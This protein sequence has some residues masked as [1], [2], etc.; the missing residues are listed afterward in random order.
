M[1]LTG[2]KTRVI[3]VMLL[4]ISITGGL[5]LARGHPS[6]DDPHAGT[7]PA[8]PRPSVSSP[9]K[10]IVSLAPSITEV[11]VM[12][13][14]ASWLVGVT[15]FSDHLEAVKTVPN[16][17]GFTSTNYER[18]LSLDPDLVILKSARAGQ[19]AS[20]LSSL[21]LNTLSVRQ[22]TVED[23][24][25]SIHKIGK[26]VDRSQRAREIVRRIKRRI[27]QIRQKTKHRSRPTVLP[28]HSRNYGERIKQVSL[29]GTDS[30]LGQIVKLAGGRNVY[31]GST[32]YP[33][34]S[35]EF[36]L[37]KNPDHIID[38]TTRSVRENLSR[39]RLKKDWAMLGDVQAVRRNRIHLISK[40]YA[41]LPGP[42]F[43]LLLE[44]ITRIL[45]PEVSLPERTWTLF[46]E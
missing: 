25:R 37:H 45:H 28:V 19:Q 40:P 12:L 5:F 43:L 9:G 26:R 22:E 6:S 14:R 16:V 3:P 17:G 42:R 8:P 13:D 2:Q 4:V 1:R 10:R 34:F 24:L 41:L 11:M 36:V 21:G 15:R 32:S 46:G 39:H 23:I 31:T 20:S 38:I 18:I 30:F 27:R 35:V 29:A 7:T 33:R 44:R